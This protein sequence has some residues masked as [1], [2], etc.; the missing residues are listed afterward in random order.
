ML[1]NLVK[2]FSLNQYYMQ[3]SFLNFLK[4][5]VCSLSFVLLSAVV[6]NG[7]ETD[8]NQLS[9]IKELIIKDR[10]WD[11]GDSLIITVPLTDSYYEILQDL[12]QVEG[13]LLIGMSEEYGGAYRPV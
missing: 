5:I 4:A 3:T 13:H 7:E 2:Q 12:E 11:N 8:A 10:D 9:N 1:Q 6:A